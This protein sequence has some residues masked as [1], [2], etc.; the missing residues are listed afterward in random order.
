MRRPVDHRDRRVC[1]GTTTSTLVD[2]RVH[3]NQSLTDE[4]IHALA[5]VTVGD[6]V[7]VDTA[8]EIER[9]LE[10]SGRFE[11]VQVRVRYLSLTATDEVALVVVVRERS[12]PVGAGP[13]GRVFGAVGESALFLPILDYA[14]GYGVSYG[15]QTSFADS[16]GD[17]GRL[18]L[19]ASWGGTSRLALEADKNFSEGVVHRLQ[20]GVSLSRIE[21]PHFGVDD[22]RTRLWAR[23]DRRVL[24]NLRLAAEG[25]WA[26]V[27]FGDRADRLRRLKVMLEVDTRRDVAFPRNAVVLQ[28]AFEW[29]DVRGGRR[30]IG[31]PEYRA[32]LY[33]GLVGQSVLAFRAK[34]QGADAALPE[35]ERLLL[36]GGP[37]LRGWRFGAF[38]GDRRVNGSAEL[39]FPLN[40]PL[41]LGRMGA[42][43]F[44]DTGTVY[45]VGGSLG[46]ARFRHGAGA[47]V[48]LRV[49]LL[50][51]QLDV[52]HNLKDRVRAHVVAAVRF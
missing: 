43:V 37:F 12:T 25:G 1:S 36:G 51:L 34:F 30:V 8:E 48:F 24:P 17:S 44:I 41:S 7:T 46:G 2:L 10:A 50:Y 38:S 33:R 18:S 14:E 40:S 29:L 9:R 3:G 6:P 45:D 27:R 31:R 42:S 49:P 28:A 20:G 15:V 47:G 32:E 11:S 21:N 52:A 26:D 13:I 16:L 19:P 4:E 22:D 23:A 5:G 39:R 35:Y